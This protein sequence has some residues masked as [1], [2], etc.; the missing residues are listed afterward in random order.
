M[1]RILRRLRHD[2]LLA[3]A[4][5]IIV[6]G[7][8]FAF[9]ALLGGNQQA[10]IETDARLDN[11]QA[12]IVRLGS[13]HSNIANTDEVTSAD[14]AAFAQTRVR[15]SSELAELKL[16]LGD[17]AMYRDLEQGVTTYTDALDGLIGAAQAGALPA[18]DLLT[19]GQAATALFTLAEAIRETRE[20]LTTASTSAWRLTRIGFGGAVIFLVASVLVITRVTETRLRRALLEEERIR[21]AHERNQQVSA[22]IENISDT[23]IVLDTAGR[24]RYSSAAIE[25]ILGRT[26]ASVDGI[27]LVDLVHPDDY[28]ES[29][30]TLGDIVAGGA[31][32]DAVTMIVRV[33]RGDG[34][35]SWIE[36]VASNRLNVPGIDGIVVNARDISARR[37]DEE[38]LRFHA[39]HDPLTG[40]PNRTVFTEHVGKAIQRS[41]RAESSFAVMFIDLD[42]FKHVNDSWGHAVGD[43]LLIGIADRLR[44][45]LREV[46]TAARQGG[47]EFVLLIEDLASVAGARLVAERVH[48]ALAVPFEIVGQTYCISASVGVVVSDG[49]DDADVDDILH[50][51]DIAMYRAKREGRNRTA[52]FIPATSKQD[53]DDLLAASD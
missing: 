7:V 37:L 6:A 39:L 36:A 49:T 16:H 45:V 28:L 11:L 26:A 3:S 52:V 22:L 4:G 48:A 50:R 47:D 27:R 14:V 20:H 42:N 34:S 40:L 13:I 9:L 21:L 1:R 25:Q 35:W 46:D 19:K 2:Q 10:H 24:I 8:V 15:I 31:N 17:D 44:S 5:V 38:R 32:A 41:R 12:S 43:E 29:T 30:Q 18:G 33:R 53:T 51:A 23:I